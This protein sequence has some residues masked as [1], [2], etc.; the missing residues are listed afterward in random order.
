MTGSMFI[1]CWILSGLLN[2]PLIMFIRKNLNRVRSQC[3]LNE[4]LTCIKYGP[5]LIIMGVILAGITLTEDGKRAKREAKL[6]RI[7]E[8]RIEALRIQDRWEIL[9]L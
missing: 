8:A 2:V 3:M 9:D 7:E 4:V 1:L 5:L 6:L